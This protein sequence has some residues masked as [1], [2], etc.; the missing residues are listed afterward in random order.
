MRTIPT[1]RTAAL[2]QLLGIAAVSA[3][4][5]MFVSWRAPGLDRYAA[6]WLM[7]LRGP[8][9]APE[10][11]AIVAIAEASIARYGRFP[12][13]RSVLARAVDA[14][15]A[16]Q[17]AAIAIDV[18][19]VDPTTPA[20][21]DALANSIRKAGNVALAAQLVE[22]QAGG[23]AQWL[24]PCPAIRQSGA[25][26]GHVNVL[27]ESEGAARE[28]LVRMADDRGSA[29]L[30][31]AVETVRI[32]ER[33]PSGAVVDTGAVLG[34]GPRSIPIEA[35]G[36]VAAIGGPAGAR[37]EVMRAGRMAIDYIGPTDSFA[38]HTY[39]IADVLDGRVPPQTFH[40]HYVLIGSTAASIGERFPSPFTHL[41]DSRGN[42][43]GALMPG[44]EV[45]ANALNTILRGR[46]Y[47]R[48]S[49]A[50][51]FLLAC[52]AA[53]ATL[54]ALNVAQGRY[55]LTRQLLGLAAVAGLIVAASTLGFTRLLWVA[56]LAP[57]LVSFASAGVLGLL[58]RTL[59]TSSRLDRNIAQLAR[60]GSGLVP[61]S[62]TDEAAAI[63][64]LSGASGITIFAEPEPGK[65]RAAATFGAPVVA[66]SAGVHVEPLPSGAGYLA[67]ACDPARA[68][69][70]DV[71]RTC[72]VLADNCLAN[73]TA[74]GPRPGRS[75]PDGL[76]DKAEI[77]G[78]L[79]GRVLR[80]AR[81][82][83]LAMRSVE[84]GLLIAGS[85]GAIRFAN[86]GAAAILESTAEGLAGRGLFDR[87][88][89]ATTA[90]LAEREALVQLL[91]DRKP[92]EQ[93][94][95]VKG[96]RPRHF[97]LRIAP[98]HDGAGPVTGLVATLS[99]ITRQK[100]LHQTQKDVMSLV[101]H[102]M[103]TPLSAIQG[104]SELLANYDVAPDRRRELNSAINDE[105][106]RL[107]RMI[108][109]YLDITRLE[110]GTV[111]PRFGA[112]R[113]EQ[114][115]ERT[116]LLVEPVAAARAIRL[117]RA[118]ASGLPSLVADADLIARATENLVSNAIKYSPASTVIT[119]SLREAGAGRLE[120]EVADQGYGI[121][122]A[123]LERVFQ[124][125]YRVPRPQD[126]EVPGTG[127]GLALVRE[128]AEL[129][130]G[131]V[132]VTSQVGVGSTFTVTL[133]IHPQEERMRVV[134]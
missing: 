53:A 123:D 106:K 75:I 10:D 72:A 18:L 108:T 21:D 111:Q 70:A 19:F 5:G 24:G 44:V 17:P 8:L 126:A 88:E 43:H 133:P 99:D 125:F 68:I 74:P 98:V 100:E 61:E 52:L 45:L 78:Q 82:V 69:P 36:R 37:A 83:D 20:E 89:S 35:A 50:A 2:A 31:L 118:F 114:T 12:W 110:S 39:S 3:L 92:I 113:L 122:E 7:R 119:V 25:G 1:A 87:L 30:A 105:V 34:V 67:A 56:P 71:W 57:G 112:L 14:I 54:I 62:A 127:L 86:P 38:A 104:M 6:D 102:E 121:P 40:G 41:A 131:G 63:A 66:G 48:P 33:V 22:A 46:F 51:S 130:G 80:Q 81:F 49:D 84:D 93:E 73:L 11:I 32:G 77:L 128:I 91:V 65:G 23:G 27:A 97:V 107:T 13:Q 129:H 109:Q 79:N 103:R 124:K 26:T 94:V 28:L 47:A 117:E 95:A 9:A 58:R 15:S 42:Q 132:K 101:S 59:I 120:I 76:E 64:R 85:S 60:A 96:P 134:G 16:G 4:L 55:A 116:L 29:L 90:D 115:V